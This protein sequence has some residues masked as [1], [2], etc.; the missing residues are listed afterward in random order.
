MLPVETKVSGAS[1]GVGLGLGAS[2]GFGLGRD[3]TTRV[4]GPTE[5]DGVMLGLVEPLQP[6]VMAATRSKARDTI[7]IDAGRRFAKQAASV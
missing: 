1:V 6:A 3:E 5:A 4:L 7:G 2:L